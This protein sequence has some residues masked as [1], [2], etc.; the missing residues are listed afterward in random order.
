[1]TRFGVWVLAYGAALGVADRFTG[2][3][4]AALWLLFWVC[5][6]VVVVYGLIRLSGFV[7][8]RLLWR[9]RRRLI[10]TYLFIAVVPI[11]LI[12]LLVGIRDFLVSGQ[13]ASFLVA[14]KLRDH[15]DELRQLNRAVAHMTHKA[16][17]RTP[18]ALL[19][20]LQRYYVNELGQHAASYPGLR[21]TIRLGPRVR[22]FE[23]DGKPLENP[24][25]VPAW[26]VRE[27]FAG[28][29]ID[30]G[31]FDIRA[32]D[33]SQTPLGELVLI[34]SQP[35]T[36]ELLDVA[37]AGIGPVTVIAPHTRIRGAEPRPRS[38]GAS[39]V[40]PPGESGEV[41]TIRS[42][43]RLVPPAA[44]RADFTVLGASTLEP[45][46]WGGER[47]ERLKEPVIVSVTTR[48]LT[49]NAQI[50][51]TLGRFSQ[52]YITALGVVA[53]I[54]LVI[55]LFAL[56]IGVRL[57]RSITTTVDKL[58]DG[59]E[60]VKAGDFSYRIK[61]PARDQLSA[62][63]EAF[64]N[65]TASVEHLLKESQEKSHLES[66][67]EIAREVQSQLFPRTPPR[68]PGFE[69]YGMCKPARVVSGDY[70]D[71]LVLGA[72]RVG[73]VLGD[74]SG[75][76]I[77]AALLMAAI[78]SALRAQFYN[79]VA[80]SGL[81]A[82]APVTTAE[83]VARLNRQ[84]FENTPA[85]KY[86]TFFY[87]VYDGET[88]KLTYTNAGHLPPVIFRRGRIERLQTGGTVVGL[89]SPCSYEQAEIQLE[90]G[91]LLLA[92][93]DGITEPENTYGEEFGEARVLDVARRA[94]N[95]PPQIMVEEICR[96]L[97]DWTGS[98]DLQDDVTLLVAKAVS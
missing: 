60:R 4:P 48:I 66:E 41:W 19:D 73:L 13:I 15:A 24:V 63:G 20:G 80:P 38:S 8:Q 18:E 30:Q 11:L 75:K 51:A 25:T 34:L 83:V 93:T 7:W 72:N 54:F 49:L 45:I 57:T 17:D 39:L 47:E 10:V 89:F 5:L 14:S 40:G 28:I 81:S 35:L 6:V 29:V 67:L 21:V 53:A 3:V 59:T 33:R 97:A 70:Y 16:V 96:S 27:E 78:Q 82:A 74:V 22:S 46:V 86:A 31:E 88:R 62:L 58:H 56:V 92:M 68:I 12:V 91:D 37:G 65:M 55:E 95:S 79:G 2:G 1:M 98:P 32:L 76:G 42:K 36:P 87:A 94:L 71:F 85:E 50:L 23:L 90:P 69:L 77:S 43:N 61:L 64:D 44:N 52:V 84:L 26:L 9:L